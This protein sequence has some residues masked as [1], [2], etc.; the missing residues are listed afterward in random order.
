MINI[1]TGHTTTEEG[2]I[3]IRVDADR[4][5]LFDR[6]SGD[7]VTVTYSSALPPYNLYNSAVVVNAQRTASDMYYI[8]GFMF[9]FDEFTICRV[10]VNSD[11]TPLAYAPEENGLCKSEGVVVE[12]QD[13]DPY[14]FDMTFGF[15]LYSTPMI[16]D[17]CAVPCFENYGCMDEYKN[18]I[19]NLVSPAISYNWQ[20]VSSLIGKDGISVSLTTLNDVN[21]G[22][23]ITTSDTTK[24]SVTSSSVLSQIVNKDDIQQRI[25]P[26]ADAG[27]I[28]GNGANSGDQSSGFAFGQGEHEYPFPGGGGGLYGGYKGII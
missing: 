21:G 10:Y 28:S 25:K 18:Y 26:G 9:L 2:D 15:G 14:F 22:D 6:S 8:F 5:P 12:V 13:G 20:S 1:F 3:I 19:T 27:G 11:Y 24:F 7:S 17:Y 4:L 23:A 16:I